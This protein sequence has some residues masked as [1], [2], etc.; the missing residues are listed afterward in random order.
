MRSGGKDHYQH[1]LCKGNQLEAL[2][3]E[4]HGNGLWEEPAT[5][6]RNFCC[7]LLTQTWWMV[8]GVGLV[9]VENALS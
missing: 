9:V 2:L 8:D 5:W 4:L 7:N 6:I 3:G 1:S